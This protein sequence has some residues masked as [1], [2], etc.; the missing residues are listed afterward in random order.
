LRR[1]LHS[2]GVIHY[3]DPQLLWR[4][5]KPAVSYLA[6]GPEGLQIYSPEFRT[7]EVYAQEQASQK[8]E[9]TTRWPG[10]TLD[11]VVLR[12][13]YVGEILSSNQEHTRIRFV[14]R[15]SERPAEVKSIEVALTSEFRIQSWRLHEVDGDEVFLNVIE[16]RPHAKVTDQQLRIPVAEDAKVIRYDSS[17]GVEAPAS[18]SPGSPKGGS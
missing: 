5:E 6:L 13:Q 10:M 8:A 18:S 7:L 17:G 14:P 2:S 1:P 9:Q 11:P 4:T 12:K 15:P 16:F 3:R